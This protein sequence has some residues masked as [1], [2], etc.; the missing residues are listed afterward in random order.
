MAKIINI[1]LQSFWENQNLNATQLE[2]AAEL[3]VIRDL[4][5]F[6]EALITLQPMKLILIIALL[7]LLIYAIEKYW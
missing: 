4:K 6:D 1:F 5:T 2:W 3:I 7:F